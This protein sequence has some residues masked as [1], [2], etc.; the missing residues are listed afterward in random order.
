MGERRRGLYEWRLRWVWFGEGHAEDWGARLEGGGRCHVVA[1]AGVRFAD[2]DIMV[3]G[4]ERY[5]EGSC[6]RRV[7]SWVAFVVAARSGSRSRVCSGSVKGDGITTLVSRLPRCLS[8]TKKALNQRRRP[9]GGILAE[10]RAEGRIAW[11]QGCPLYGK[12]MA[13]HIIFRG[14][15]HCCKGLDQIVC[16]C[17]CVRLTMAL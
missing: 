15:R 16:C 6:V 8:I 9:A 3:R 5:I 7:V 14:S 11:I 12:G 4:T 2:V 10:R 1:C 13:M 17:C